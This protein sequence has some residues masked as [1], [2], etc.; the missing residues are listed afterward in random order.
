MIIEVASVLFSLVQFRTDWLSYTTMTELQSDANNHDKPRHPRKNPRTSPTPGSP[1]PSDLVFRCHHHNDD[2]DDATIILYN[3]HFVKLP[4]SS[5]VIQCD[6]P[7][8][9]YI[10]TLSFPSLDTDQTAELA[11]IYDL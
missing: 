9:V 4:I 6:R 1:Q 2:D 11:S 8:L 10:L 3:C 5:H 7:Q